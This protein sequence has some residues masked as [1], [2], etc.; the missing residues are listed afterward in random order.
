MELTEIVTRKKVLAPLGST[1]NKHGRIIGT[2]VTGGNDTFPG[3]AGTAAVK[4][5]DLNVGK[6]GLTE[7]Q[8]RDAGLDYHTALIPD[9]DHASY[10]PGAKDVLIKVIAEK[11]TGR[12]LGGQMVGPGDTIKRLD[13][14]ATSLTFGSNVETLANLDLAY[15]PPYNSA[16]DPLHDA[17]NV[18]RNKEAGYFPSLTPQQVKRKIDNNEDFILLDVRS[19]MEWKMQRIPAPQA[20]LIPLPEL[21]QRLNELPPDKEIVTVCRTSIRAYQALRILEGAGFKNVKAVDGS[22]QAWPYETEKQVL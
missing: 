14:V 4:V 1:A 20:K 3:I 11:K 15:A 19:N 22:I 12:V 13:V 16:M 9:S 6:T 7:K 8:A 5:F 10:Y 18:I 17:A 2:N 21:R